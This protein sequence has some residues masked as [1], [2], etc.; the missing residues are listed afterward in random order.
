MRQDSI[1]IRDYPFPGAE[2]EIAAVNHGTNWPVVHIS[3][4]DLSV[5]FQPLS[6][7]LHSGASDETVVPE[8]DSMSGMINCRL[9]GKTM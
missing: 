3:P 7:A 5:N 4:R 9:S 8:N 1:I 6:A 2:Q